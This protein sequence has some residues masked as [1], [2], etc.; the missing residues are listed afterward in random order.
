MNLIFIAKKKLKFKM[1]F[2]LLYILPNAGERKRKK[3]TTKEVDDKE[4]EDVQVIICTLFMKVSV[5]F[6]FEVK[7]T[8][9]KPY[10]NSY[11]CFLSSCGEFLNSNII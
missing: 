9:F 11:F 5:C 2:F 6:Y 7:L 3:E 8:D 1:S 4:D 10:Q